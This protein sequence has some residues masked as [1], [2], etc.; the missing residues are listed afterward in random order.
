MPHLAF[1]ADR[2]NFALAQQELKQRGIAFDFQD[3]DIS[4]SIYFSDP[5]GHKLEITTYE[6]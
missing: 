4:H 6:I 2:Q 5:D 3:H 1:R